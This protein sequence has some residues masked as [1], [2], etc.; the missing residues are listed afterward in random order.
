VTRQSPHP[1]WDTLKFETMK[2]KQELPIENKLF[3]VSVNKIHVN[4]IEGL[5][6]NSIAPKSTCFVRFLDD[7]PN[8]SI[9]LTRFHFNVA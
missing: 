3:Q 8:F 7:F 9:P 4:G 6:R 5:V 1:V 2:K